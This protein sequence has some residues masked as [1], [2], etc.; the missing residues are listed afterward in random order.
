MG[1]VI[2][3]QTKGHRAQLLEA[4]RQRQLIRLWRGDME[5]G[6]FCGYVA[7]IG[8]EFFMLRVIGDGIT[9]DGLY[10]M[11]HRDITEL[12]SPDKHATF[13]LKAIAHRGLRPQL[14]KDFPLEDISQVVRA[15]ATRAPVIGIHVDSEDEAEVCYI[16]RL[17][18]TEDDGFNLQ[19][20]S[21]DAEW[22]REPSFFAWDEVSTVSIDDPYAT[23]LAA[24][25]GPVPEL[26]QSGGDIGGHAR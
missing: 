25:A 9:D 12:E 17:I 10:V 14:P 6:S 3:F 15:A 8:R 2:Q 16:G 24:V 19:E 5:H 1:K 21:P 11:R 18:D 7:G 22:L 4:Q 20:I 26:R 23:A 13:M